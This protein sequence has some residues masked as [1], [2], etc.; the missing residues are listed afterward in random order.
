MAESNNKQLSLK[1]ASI[2]GVGLL[3]LIAS[4][5]I[6]GAINNRQKL[7]KKVKDDISLS[8]AGKQ[9]ILGP[10]LSVPCRD[11]MGDKKK[12]HDVLL[13]PTTFDV[14]VNAESQI[15]SRGIFDVAVYQT[16][17]K[18]SCSF[19]PQILSRDLPNG[20]KELDWANARFI[21]CVDDLKG[22]GDVIVQPLG[23]SPLPITPGVGLPSS[24]LTGVQIPI[25]LEQ[26]KTESLN[27]NCEINLK[28]SDS[29][30][31]MPIGQANKIDVS[32]NWSDP[33]F[34][35]YFLPDNKSITKAGF[36]ADW[37]V[38]SIAT[39]IPKFFS[40]EEL[41]NVKLQDKS[42]AVRLLKPGD[43]YQQSE[44][45]TKYSFL[46][47]IYTFLVLFLYEVI[48]KIKI[49]I[50]QYGVIA[51]AMLYFPVLLTSIAEHL[52]FEI[53]FWL[54]SIAIISQISFYV[55]GFLEKL[56]ERLFFTTILSSLYLYLFIVL[57]LEEV[58][59][60]VGA[61]GM[62]FGITVTMFYTRKL[63][64]L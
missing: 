7:F 41:N 11:T 32:S 56:K 42:I 38:N 40:S 24:S 34:V 20:N 49:H 52:S 9:I 10:I 35:G 64:G 48:K 46:F 44:R 29:F 36:K 15:K 8:W 39:N 6:D 61:I 30:S 50:L 21:I 31:V 53:A 63:N 1:F 47:I 2:L 16:K 14:N 60:L 23:S 25:N 26:K 62:F 57:R 18:I 51:A 3:F 54:T 33:S 13:L 19:N 12:R 4:F 5:F 55:F 37:S 28:G 27:V 43:H 17:I 59:F 22:L 58:A 45:C